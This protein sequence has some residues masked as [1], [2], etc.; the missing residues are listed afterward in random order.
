[1]QRMSGS[2]D[3]L[4]E[5]GVAAHR[6]GAAHAPENTLAAVREAVR[7][8]AHQ[9]EVDLRRTADGAIV[10]MHDADIARTTDGDGAV[11]KFTLRELRGFDAGAHFSSRHVGE[12][13]PTLAELLDAVPQDRWLNLQIKRGEPIAG[14]AAR[15]LVRA[16]R[17]AHAFLA[18]D[19][20]SAREARA[21]HPDVLLCDLARQRSREAYVD[22]AAALGA[23]FVQ[24]HHLR[25]TPMAGEIAAARAAGLLVNFFC[26][27]DSD[28][29]ALFAA[30]VDFPLVD[31]IDRAMRIA[32]S[33]GVAPLAPPGAATL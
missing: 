25:G 32:E 15:E 28:V 19:E 6:G 14:E 3:E 7:R 31:D 18:C 16:G 20:A 33:F 4:P 13:V 23:R 10:V 27:P 8:G 24:F 9:I 22:H 21:V 17:L 5:R 1:M 29:R 26:A 11:A 12:N 30:G 2:R